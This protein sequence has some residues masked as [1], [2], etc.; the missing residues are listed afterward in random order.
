MKKQQEKRPREKQNK[1]KL[2]D[3][4]PSLSQLIQVP[5]KRRKKRQ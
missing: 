5:L 4:L 1:R 3:L 2:G